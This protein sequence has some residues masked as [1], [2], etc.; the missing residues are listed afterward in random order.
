MLIWIIFAAM[1][2]AAVLAVLWP[3]G[4]RQPAGFADTAGATALYRAQLVEIDRDLGRRLIGGAEAEA[5][6]AEA[7]RRLLR[8]SAGEAE[9]PGES[10]PALRRRR[11][12][13]AIALSCVPL[14]ALLVYGA[15]GSPALRDQPLAARLK[16]DPSQDFAVALARIEAHL[17]ANPSDGKGW[18]VLAPV[19]LRQ[20]RFEDAAKA[21]AAAIRHDGAT[22][23]RHAGAAE[24]Q[25]LAAGGVV[26][27]S[28]RESL[29]AALALEPANPRARFFMAMAQEQDGQLPAAIASLESLL[30]DAPAEAPWTAPVK[31]RLQALRGNAS[32]AGAIA[33]LPEAERGTAIRGMV[34]GLAARLAQGGGDLAEWSRLVRSQAVLGEREAAQRSLATARQR[35]AGDASAAAAL[36]A[37]RAELGLSE[38]AP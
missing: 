9:Q 10:E 31:E 18:S 37:L 5:A 19:Y 2:G 22:P 17:A 29:A 3:L 11:A 20:G 25:I 28:A 27:A 4:R 26:T 21:F 6:R 33:D 35:L 34:D 14:L 24:A 16:A 32:P 13:S 1:T 36:D 30:A 8:A 15:Y 7:G 38:T 12:A 23:E